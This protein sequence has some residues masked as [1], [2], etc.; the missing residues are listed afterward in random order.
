MMGFHLICRASFRVAA[1]FWLSQA[2]TCAFSATIWGDHHGEPHVF[3]QLSG[4][5]KLVTEMSVLVLARSSQSMLMLIMNGFFRTV[6]MSK[7]CVTAWIRVQSLPF[8]LLLRSADKGSQI[9]AILSTPATAWHVI[10]CMS[11]SVNQKFTC[12]HCSRLWNVSHQEKPHTW[13]L[14]NE[15][16]TCINMHTSCKATYSYIF[17]MRY[18]YRF[19]NR[20]H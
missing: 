5:F 4:C 3:S 9:V 2:N 8:V 16:V 6:Q 19:V 14:V 7:W 1:F 17:I 11:I 13:F 18:I 20:H 15:H 10:G 12:S